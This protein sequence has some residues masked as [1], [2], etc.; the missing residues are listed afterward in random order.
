MSVLASQP[1]NPEHE[2]GEFVKGAVDA[3]G[4][5]SFLGCVRPKSARGRVKKLELQAYSPMTEQGIEQA[6]KRANKNWP[7]ISVKIIHRVGD[8]LSGEPIVFVAAA[9]MHR[10]DAFEAAD[11]IMD[12]LKTDAVFWKKEVTEDGEYWI[13]P[14]DE[15]Y[16][17]AERWA[18]RTSNTP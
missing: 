13:E 14:R 15:D 7:L 12:Y 17:D 18:Q 2:L 16:N 5:V 6:I 3:G 9:A 1:F 8:V 4:I 10:R 11:Y